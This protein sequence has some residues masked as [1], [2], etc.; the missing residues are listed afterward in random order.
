MGGRQLHCSCRY[1]A[2]LVY[3]A[4][5]IGWR[6]PS[7][8]VCIQMIGFP[9]RVSLLFWRNIRIILI[10]GKRYQPTERRSDGLLP[11]RMLL[12]SSQSD[13]SADLLFHQT[14]LDL[15]VILHCQIKKSAIFFPD[16][17]ILLFSGFFAKTHRLFPPFRHVFMQAAV[18][19]RSG[20]RR[21]LSADT[22]RNY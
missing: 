6:P 3:G 4:T 8:V 9:G 20:I 19:F 2:L 16:S 7:R 5:F 11:F 10:S 15:H 18:L 17:I 12:P 13:Q 22:L 1:P 21:E 14:I